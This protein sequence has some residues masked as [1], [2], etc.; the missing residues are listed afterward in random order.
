MGMGLV[1]VTAVLA[2][3]LVWLVLLRRS[4]LQYA[5]GSE[6]RRA[7]HARLAKIA[8]LMLVGLGVGID[9]ALLIVTRYRSGLHDGL[10]PHEAASLAI[11]TSGRAVLFAGITVVISLLGMFLL[12]LDFMRS[13]SIGAVLAVLMTMLGSLTLLP[14]MLGFVGHNI[15]RPNLRRH[16]DGHGRHAGNRGNHA[17]RLI[18][19]QIL[20]GTGGRRVVH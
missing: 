6:G 15:D 12:N 9:Y 10:T 20:H 4:R 3:V 13:M 18:P 2:A 19:Q 8:A 1:F 17:L 11:D 14:A 5:S 7:E 16:F